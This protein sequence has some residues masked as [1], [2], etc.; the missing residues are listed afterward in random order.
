MVFL[1]QSAEQSELVPLIKREL[2]RQSN[3]GWQAYAVPTFA[4]K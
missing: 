1:D 4:Q 2:E 3:A